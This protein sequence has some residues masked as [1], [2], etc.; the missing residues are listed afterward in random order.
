MTGEESHERRGG[1]AAAHRSPEKAE[2]GWRAVRSTPS[3]HGSECLLRHRM[4]VVL[5]KRLEDVLP[6]PAART[7]CEREHRWDRDGGR[8][9]I[10]HGGLDGQLAEGLVS[11][12]GGVPNLRVDRHIGGKHA[13]LRHHR[14][15]R[16]QVGDSLRVTSVGRVRLQTAAVH[17]RVSCCVPGECSGSC[18]HERARSPYARNPGHVKRATRVRPHL[19]WAIW[20]ERGL[21]LLVGFHHLL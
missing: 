9:G 11:R 20:M 2:C 16:V 5:H 19:R 17:E 13:A 15:V 7:L 4:V 8:C 12:A 6:R 18:V 3:L 21:H 10:P 1:E 14:A